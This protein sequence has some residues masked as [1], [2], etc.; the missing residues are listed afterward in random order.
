MNNEEWQKSWREGQIGFH[1]RSPHPLL[2]TYLPELKLT[3]GDTIFVPLC[4]ASIDMNYL[5]EQGYRVVGCELSNIAC[6]KFFEEN[7]LAYEVTKKGAFDYYHSHNIQLF[8]GDIFNL[9][10]DEIGTPDAIY[11]RAALIAFPQA[12]QKPYIHKIKQLVPTLNILLITLTHDNDGGPP[13]STDVRAVESLFSN[14]LIKSLAKST[15]TPSVA[16]LEERGK[17][18]VQEYIYHI[19]S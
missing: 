9:T 16:G 18:N 3:L 2:I 11:D 12:Q 14:D 17:R 1:E 4:G 6:R 7:Q 19:S 5:L 8:C 15:D 13:Y 10:Q